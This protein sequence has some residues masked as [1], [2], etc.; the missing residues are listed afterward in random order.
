MPVIQICRSPRHSKY[1]RLSKE[2]MLLDTLAYR[3][4]QSGVAVPVVQKT[5]SVWEESESIKAVSSVGTS[6][7]C[8]GRHLW[9]AH[10]DVTR[11][12]L[13]SRADR[14]FLE[15]NTGDLR[16]KDYRTKHS[17]SGFR[18]LGY[19]LWRPEHSRLL[20]LSK[21]NQSSFQCCSL[22]LELR[23]WQRPNIVYRQTN[24]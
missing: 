1:V 19:T 6:R 23:Q 13:H 3:R 16:G 20:T 18:K 21:S 10:A 7:V 24:R 9:A 22:H 2:S 15:A 8:G 17:H 4:T 14:P 12:Q 11:I 5:L